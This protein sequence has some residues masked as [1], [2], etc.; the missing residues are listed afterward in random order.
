MT[1]DLISPTQTLDARGLV[2]PMPTVRLGQAIREVYPGHY[3]GSV[4]GRG[5]DG[6]TISTIGR[7]RRSNPALQLSAEAFAQ[8]QT[9]KLPALPDD[10][11]AIKRRNLG[12]A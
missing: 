3:A 5:M 6:K 8:F 9:E 4:C 10:F 7:E 1:T 11:H 12:H 2:C